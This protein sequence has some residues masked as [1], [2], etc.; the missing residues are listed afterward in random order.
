MLVLCVAREQAAI[1]GHAQA[2]RGARGHDHGAR[3]GQEFRP[4]QTLRAALA[5]QGQRIDTEH[6]HGTLLTA[7]IDAQTAGDNG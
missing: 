6:L 1:D 3:L 2:L 4:R 7:D 5:A